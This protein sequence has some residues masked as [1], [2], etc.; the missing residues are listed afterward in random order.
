MHF[1]DLA[2]LVEHTAQEPVTRPRCVMSHIHRIWALRGLLSP[3]SGEALPQN[4]DNRSSLLG[5]ALATECGFRRIAPL[6]SVRIMSPSLR[7]AL[8]LE[9]HLTRRAYTMPLPLKAAICAVPRAILC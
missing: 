2:L 1:S 6:V 3:A 4:L 9:T 7:M 5:M 8:Q